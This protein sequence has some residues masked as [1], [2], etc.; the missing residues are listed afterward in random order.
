MAGLTIK[1]IEAIERR[2]RAGAAVPE[3]TPDG[4][5]LY[6]RSRK[7]GGM[8]FILRR[9][10]FKSLTLGPASIGIAEA[11]KRARA[12]IT[13]QEQGI[14]P[15]V[16]KAKS[17]AAAKVEATDVAETFEEVLDQYIERHVRKK[18][19][20]AKEVERILRHDAMPAW[21]KMPL[22]EIKRRHVS[23]LVD[24]I[25]DRG[26]ERMAGL[27]LA[28]LSAFFNW[29]AGR[30]HLDDNPAANVPMPHKIV[31]RDR[32]L[33][34]EELRLVWT[35]A[36]R[37]GWPFEPL[38]YL[39][40]LTGQRETEIARGRWSEV[41]LDKKIWSLPPERT[42]NKLPHVFP[43]SDHAVEILKRLPRSEGCDFIFTTNG[44]SPVSGFSRAKERLDK[45]TIHFNGGV[46][47][48][49]WRWHDLRRTAATG[50]AK[51]KTPPHVIEATLN[52]IS[53]A[54]AGVAGV[55]NQHDYGPEMRVALDA[56]AR[57]LMEIVNG[58]DESN[59]IP[60]ITK[61]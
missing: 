28:N 11:R 19:R 15:A 61:R 4:Q 7:T 2:V 33:S 3:Y 26:S 1:E 5:G 27:T 36:K 25:V 12:A 41:D 49:P 48:P 20:T 59:V 14:D 21:G 57:R 55:Y 39:W 54:K 44:K 60:M 37:L 13:Q 35:A 10:G 6:L 53:G 51:I 8:S 58:E 16:I 30:G 18:L 34:D 38:F 23:E 52:H 45:H 42:K 22:A 46:A 9:W 29:A 50:L 17:R 43:L 31:K 47:I 40:I 32:F 56:W 24:K